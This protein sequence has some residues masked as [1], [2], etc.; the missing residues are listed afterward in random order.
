LLG[1]ISQTNVHTDQ[2]GNKKKSNKQQ[3]LNSQFANTFKGAMHTL[4]ESMRYKDGICCKKSCPAC[5]CT[6]T[7]YIPPRNFTKSVRGIIINS[8]NNQ[9]GYNTARD[10][11]ATAVL[12]GILRFA[13]VSS[14]FSIHPST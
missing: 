7:M 14:S 13:S 4:W 5:I 9:K 6:R 11:V 1:N 10:I 3:F 8:N 12:I 2:P